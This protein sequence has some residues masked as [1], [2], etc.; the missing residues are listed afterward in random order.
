MNSLTEPLYVT[1]F[2]EI[3]WGGLLVAITM[4]MHGFGMLLVLRAAGSLTHRFEPKPSF[5]NA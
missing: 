5:A 1:R 3:F 4:V 2:E